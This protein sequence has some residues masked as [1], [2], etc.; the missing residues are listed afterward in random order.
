MALSVLVT[1]GAFEA[2]DGVLVH[3]DLDR[4]R[5]EVWSRWT[6]PPRLSVHGKGFAGGSIHDGRL[7]VAAHAAVVRW[8]LETAT[9][10]GTL[11]Q[12]DFNDL[13]GVSVVDD[14]LL[15]V[16]TG[17]DAIERFD[18]DG[19]FLAR[20]GM[21]PGWVQ[22]RRMDG[23]DPESF[24]EACMVGW[25]GAAPRWTP[26]RT[27]DGY[28]S[29]REDRLALPFHR[30][31]VPDRIHPNHVVQ[32]PD[33]ALVTC[34]L[35]GTIR[36]LATL[37][38]AAT[39]DGHPH[40]GCIVDG[41]LW[42]T[43]ID[44]GIWRIPLPLGTSAPARVADLAKGGRV[45]WCRGLLVLDDVIVAGLT[46]VRA[47]RLPRHRWSDADP[48]DSMTGL[49]VLDRHTGSEL[50]CVDMTDRQRHAKI[51]SILEIR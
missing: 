18:L 32:A 39:V 46:E 28:H 20:H 10:D 11:H 7:Y 15:V 48:H 4:E 33:G 8:D 47:D 45:G 26:R 21:L 16:N 51:Y 30:Q 34:L 36:T 2:S 13:H 50:A 9:V 42:L 40:D 23:D 14:R 25:D 37:E 44:G 35:D 19:R 38:P 31:K 5:A 12:P 24:D 43:T 17:C 49:V 22:A 3:V 27:G 41:C 1:A 6:P 29:G